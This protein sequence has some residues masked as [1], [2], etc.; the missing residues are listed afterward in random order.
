MFKTRRT[1]DDGVRM[2]A[3]AA[4]PSKIG[5]IVMPSPPV[6]FSTLN[7][8]LAASRLGQIRMLA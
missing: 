5:P 6:T 3:V 1:V 4:A 8:M 2:C 7:S